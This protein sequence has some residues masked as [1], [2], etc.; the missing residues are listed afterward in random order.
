M[1]HVTACRQSFQAL[2]WLKNFPVF[3]YSRQMR[4]PEK[5]ANQ[6]CNSFNNI[7]FIL[8]KILLISSAAYLMSPFLLFCRQPGT[9]RQRGWKEGRK[10][11]GK[12]EPK[13]FVY[14]N[15]PPSDGV[16]EIN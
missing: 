10:K 1:P 4:Q 13:N 15:E 14:V 12:N 11:E 16:K 3:P 6:I 7:V 2:F 9:I 8:I 5:M